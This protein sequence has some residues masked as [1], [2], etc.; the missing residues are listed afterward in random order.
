MANQ[1]LS[2]MEF[3]GICLLYIQFYVDCTFLLPHMYYPNLEHS[4]LEMKKM[5]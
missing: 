4:G 1:V 5:V 3:L 2:P